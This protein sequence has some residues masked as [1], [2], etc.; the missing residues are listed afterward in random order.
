MG[1]VD[2]AKNILGLQPEPNT[3]A[4][5]FAPFKTK[6]EAVDFVNKEFKKRQELKRDYELRW[7]LN[8]NFLNNNQYCDI[9]LTAKN[10]YQQ[11]P[12][13]DWQ[14]MEVYNQIRIIFEARLAALK[15]NR[16]LPFVRP[17]GNETR[18]IATAN[19]SK[20]VLRGLDANVDMNKI[21]PM[22]NAW[23]EL[24]GCCFIK[25]RWNPNAGNY[26]GSDNQGDV[27]DGD[28]EKYIV[29]S[30]EMFPDNNFANGLTGCKSI[31]HARP[32]SVDDIWEEWDV[33]VK[34]RKVDVFTLS[35][36][37]IGGGLGY[38]TTNPK[39][40]ATT[41]D[42]AEIVK[43]LMLLP[44][45]KYPQGLNIIVAGTTLL[46]I[47]PFVYRIGKNGAYG[48]PF[49][50]QMCIENPGFFWPTSI[51]ERLIPIQRAYNAIKNRKHEI[52]NRKAIGNLAVQDDGNV[53]VEELQRE[54]LFPGKIHLYSRDG[55][56]PMFIENKDSTTDFAQ[57]E[58]SLRNEFAMIS[59]VSPFSSQSQ[60]P[61][62][63]VS[64]DAIEQ[65]KESDES[66][67]TLAKENIN[68]AA[69]E[70]WKIDLRM[71]R[72]FAPQGPRLLKYVG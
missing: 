56:A 54:G 2:M 61:G 53:D 6:D 9:N 16:P 14:E 4:S 13:Y 71:Y 67:I 32:M 15:K 40:T 33:V 37:N 5:N 18:D 41:M 17:S 59:G 64:G 21:R 66:R 63:V 45:K 19:I 50:M 72:Q 60:L 46:H 28:I 48:L 44:C 3:E 31:I 36:S 10:I 42:D 11:T 57:E 20:R 58:E 47:G 39:V 62:G 52:L 23:S 30:F 29:N 43:E 35:Q 7:M 55:K 70:G 22:V 8:I 26:L 25:H 51:I 65:I 27:Y 69:I 68:Q 49:E 1:L 24:T 12:A 34:G 38:Y